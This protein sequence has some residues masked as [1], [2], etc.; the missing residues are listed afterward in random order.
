MS[1][2]GVF[3]QRRCGVGSTCFFEHVTANCEVEF[4]TLKNHTTHD[5][6]VIEEIVSTVSG[7]VSVAERA[8][9]VR[10]VLG[11]YSQ[12][13]L[14]FIIENNTHSYDRAQALRTSRLDPCARP[15]SS[16]ENILER[17]TR[18]SEAT[19]AAARPAHRCA[20]RGASPDAPLAAP[21]AVPPAAPAFALGTP[22]RSPRW[23]DEAVCYTAS[24]TDCARV[25]RVAAA[26]SGRRTARA[27]RVVSRRAACVTDLIDLSARASLLTL[28]GLKQ[29]FAAAGFAADSYVSSSSSSRSVAACRRRV[30]P[31]LTH[32]VTPRTIYPLFREYSLHQSESRFVTHDAASSRCRGPST[33][34]PPPPVAHSFPPP[35]LLH[36]NSV[37]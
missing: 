11:H 27:T 30:L 28:G 5:M 19:I 15:F 29:E 24:R 35:P 4:P 12:G 32:R 36:S 31:S 23:G 6:R 20:P 25:A 1:H 16:A 3:A 17:H 2:P 33:P 34:A 8:S 18:E 10:A 37:T 26:T 9:A 13:E 22:P 14:D 21:S 7:D